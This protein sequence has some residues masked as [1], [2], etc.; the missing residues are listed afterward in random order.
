MTRDRCA[1]ILIPSLGFFAFLPICK[2]KMTKSIQNDIFLKKY[3]HIS[4][5]FS[6][7][8]AKLYILQKTYNSLVNFIV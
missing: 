8:A 1:A 4:K 7:F 2:L 6:N 5:T 3:L